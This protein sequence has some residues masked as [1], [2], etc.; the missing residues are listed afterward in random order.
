MTSSV[1]PVSKDRVEIDRPRYQ[2]VLLEENKHFPQQCIKE[3]RAAR[4]LQSPM[5]ASQ[6]KC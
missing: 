6:N 2:N 3:Q 5:S 1:Q 4:F